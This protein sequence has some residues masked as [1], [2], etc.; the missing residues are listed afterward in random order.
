VK[1]QITNLRYGGGIDQGTESGLGD[2]SLLANVL[3]YQYL[4][5]DFTLNWTLLGGVKFPTGSSD[6]IKEELNEVEQPIGPP[7]GIHGHDLT[8]GT[9]SYDGILG[10]GVYARWR[11][12]F[13]A[14]T[15]QYAIR[16]EGDFKYQFADDLTWT[17]A[18]GYYLALAHRYTLALQA[19]VSGEYKDTDTFRGESASDTGITA[20]YLGPQLSFTWESRLSA[21]LAVDFPMLLDNT[22]LQTVPDY[23]IRGG[24]TWHF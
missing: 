22:A 14:A 11:R 21:Q 6:R 3:A 12:G 17:F 15:V 5:E 9:G 7:S 24:L 10:S 4:T 20:V 1:Q 19:V 2:V 16:S 18:P 13:V 23:R 8:L